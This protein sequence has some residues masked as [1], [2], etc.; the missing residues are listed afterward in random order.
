MTLDER[1]CLEHVL[2]VTM[3]PVNP[4]D[5][6][7]GCYQRVSRI[8]SSA[9]SRK[10]QYCLHQTQQQVELVGARGWPA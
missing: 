7:D 3:A 8:S 4:L 5:S 2:N 6:R 9:A 10:Y 1:H